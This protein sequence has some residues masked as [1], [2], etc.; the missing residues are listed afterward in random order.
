[1]FKQGG[2]VVRFDHEV[3]GAVDEIRHFVGDVAYVGHETECAFAAFDEVS[4][5]VAAVMRDAERTDRHWADCHGRAFFEHDGMLLVYLSCDAVVLPYALMYKGSGVDGHVEF[6]AGHAGGLH[7][8]GVV[9]RD[10]QGLDVRHGEAVV[11]EVFLDCADADTRIDQY[12][13]AVGIEEVAVSTAPAAEADKFHHIFIFTAKVAKTPD[14]AKP[15]D[16][17]FCG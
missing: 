3:I 8:V 16:A 2:V 15:E 13:I 17:V 14:T 4:I 1:M 12:A 9:V 7:V 10:E 11:A 6:M 5:V